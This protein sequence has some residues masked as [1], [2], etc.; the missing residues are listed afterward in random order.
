MVAEN[1][2]GQFDFLTLISGDLFR[3]V[4][5]FGQVDNLLVFRVEFLIGVKPGKMVKGR[6][7]I[8]IDKRS[9]GYYSRIFVPKF[10]SIF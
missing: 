2:K 3:L 6:I 7:G 9:N 8:V 4:F 1:Y 10:K 5:S